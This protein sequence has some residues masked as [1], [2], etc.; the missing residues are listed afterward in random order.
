MHDDRV[1]LKTHH[2]VTSM[3]DGVREGFAVNET[4]VSLA[5]QDQDIT[6]PQRTQLETAHQQ[7]A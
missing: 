1:T 6:M 4:L 2:Y 3:D 7:K 5:L